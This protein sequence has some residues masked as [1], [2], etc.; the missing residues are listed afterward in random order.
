MKLDGAFKESPRRSEVSVS[1]KQKV[2]RGTGTV[3]GS[4]QVLPLA[5]DFD[6]GFVYSPAHA[7][8]TLAPESGQKRG[9]KGAE[10]R[11]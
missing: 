9:A 10:V 8:R 7:Y 6:V 5:A 3:D 4:V 11:P 1:P 2:D